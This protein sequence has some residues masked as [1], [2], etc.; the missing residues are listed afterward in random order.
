MACSKDRSHWWLEGR[1]NT[2]AFYAV[3]DSCFHNI[4]TLLKYSPQDRPWNLKAETFHSVFRPRV[5]GVWHPFLQESLEGDQVEPSRVQ[6]THWSQRETDF[7]ACQ[8]AFH[9][10]KT[11]IEPTISYFLVKD[12]IKHRG[13]LKAEDCFFVGHSLWLTFCH[14]PR[15]NTNKP[16]PKSNSATGFNRPREPYAIRVPLKNVFCFQF[17]KIILNRVVKNTAW[18]LFR[19]G[20]KTIIPVNYLIISAGISHLLLDHK[21]SEKEVVFKETNKQ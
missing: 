15:S 14:F 17:G 3:G 4:F 19:P 2:A 8:G 6:S 21:P 20:L 7:Q 12:K 5:S 11:C 9:V 16:E 10:S 1:L 18:L 13:A